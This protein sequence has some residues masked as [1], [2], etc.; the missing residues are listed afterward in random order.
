MPAGNVRSFYLFIVW[1]ALAD[2]LG[3]AIRFLPFT[4]QPPLSLFLYYSLAMAFAITGWAIINYHITSELNNTHRDD[5]SAVYLCGGLG[6]LLVTI[7]VIFAARS[8]SHFN[9]V[10]SYEEFLIGASALFMLVRRTRTRPRSYVHYEKFAGVLLLALGVRVA[11][12]V[13]GCGSASARYA[14]IVPVVY[15]QGAGNECAVRLDDEFEGAFTT[16]VGGPV[17]RPDG[18]LGLAVC[19]RIRDSGEWVVVDGVIDVEDV[20]GEARLFRLISRDSATGPFLDALAVGHVRV[21]AAFG[22]M[23]GSGVIEIVAE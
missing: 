14:E 23:T 1:L 8:L 10:F 11:A 2:A 18:G 16:L 3:V 13:A 12:M 6:V 22:D 19:A 7:E 9:V 20:G 17:G 15:Q 4:L 5:L 21:T